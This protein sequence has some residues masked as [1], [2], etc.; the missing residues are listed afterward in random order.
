[1]NEREWTDRLEQAVPE[2]PSVFHNAMLGAFAQIQEQEAQE[3]QPEQEHKIVELPRP[4]IKKRTAAI[5]LIAALLMASVAVAA[6][7]VPRILST[8]WG[9]DVTMREDFPGRVKND[10]AEITV[11]DCRVRIEEAVYDGMALYVTY[12]IRNMTVDRMMGERDPDDPLNETRYLMERDYEER[13]TWDAYWWRDCLWLN[14]VDTDIPETDMWEEGGDEPGEYICFLKYNLSTIDVQLSGNTRVAL[15]FGRD[16]HW[17][18][19]IFQ[20]LPKDENGGALEPDDGCIVFYI[21]ADVPGLERVENGPVSTWPDGTTIWTKEALF[22]PVKLYL[23]LNF[24]VPDELIDAY[25]EE[26]GSDGYYED[27]VL[28]YEYNAIDIVSD[29]VHELAL[30]DEQ[31]NLIDAH[32]NNFDGIAGWGTT[33]CRYVFPYMEDYPSPL[34]VAPVE[35]G[36]PDVSRKV[37]IRE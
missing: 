31:G 3:R 26:M 22:T 25:K 17:N 32:P 19:E 11:G 15:P 10:V 2:V 1:M 37:L 34:Y 30:V 18:Y 7:F 13:Y 14:G 5:I 16:Q 33:V 12:T 23:T 27:G 36:K 6:A 20:T 28:M 8:F 9:D 4:G 21:D 24:N 29:W 35:N